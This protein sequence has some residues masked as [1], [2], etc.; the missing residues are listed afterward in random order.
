MNAVASMRTAV[1]QLLHSSV[2]AGS[3][4]PSVSMATNA[5]SVGKLVRSSTTGLRATI[6]GAYGF[7][8]RYVTSLIGE[9]AMPAYGQMEANAAGDPAREGATA[10]SV[11]PRPRSCASGVLQ[12]A[13]GRSASSRTEATTWS[14]DT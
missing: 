5:E 13:A 7:V 11:T 10:G 8:G 3:R 12:P 4:S 1:R 2:V 14:G 9:A 6:F